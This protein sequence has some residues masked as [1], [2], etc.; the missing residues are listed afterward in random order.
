MERSDLGVI[1]PAEYLEFIAG[2]R[3]SAKT[4]EAL[5]A[6]LL[7]PASVNPVLTDRQVVTLRAMLRRIIPQKGPELDLTAYILERL[8]QGKGDGW[9]YDVLPDDRLAY[10]EGLDRLAASG[11]AEED[12]ETQDT[13][14]KA[15]AAGDVVDARWFEEVRGD[16][17]VAYI[18]HP[19]TLARLGYSGIGVGG[20]DTKHKGFVTLGPNEREAW[21]PLPAIEEGR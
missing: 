15:L 4:R 19:S 2:D 16:A 12:T 20:A 6:R 5:E 11:F 18:A 7:V 13:L 8:D 17:T 21:E 3:V 10:R 1:V 9:R 14:L